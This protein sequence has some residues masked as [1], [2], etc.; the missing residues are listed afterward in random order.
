[1]TKIVRLSHLLPERLEVAGQVRSR[2]CDDEQVAGMKLAWDFIGKELGDSLRSVLDCDL[3]GILAAGWAKAAELAGFADP[4]RH[5]PGE[6]SLVE[7]GG[8]DFSH[9][10][11]PVVAIT[12]APCPCV[13][14]KFDFVLTAHI[15]GVRLSI[16]DG[17]II[18]GDIGEVWASAQ[19]SYQGT[20]LHPAAETRKLALP[21]RLSFTPPGIRIPR[22]MP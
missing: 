22:L 10:L 3:A 20:P 13:E 8:H 18:G 9:E 12:I 14:L 1:M 17:H 21:A 15:G 2:M 6:R 4:G 7:L 11:H 19:L 5:P 16:M